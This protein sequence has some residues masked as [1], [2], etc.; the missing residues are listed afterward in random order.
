[1]EGTLS[2]YSILASFFPGNKK[3]Y[4]D[5]IFQEIRSGKN[6]WNENIFNSIH[7]IYQLSSF[8]VSDF[9]FR[10]FQSLEMGSG[11]RKNAFELK[12]GIR[13]SFF[14]SFRCT[15]N[16]T[17]DSFWHD[18]IFLKN[19]I[20]LKWNEFSSRLKKIY[21]WNPNRNPFTQTQS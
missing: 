6:N 5:L 16:V 17:C 3:N 15:S 1:M 11:S 8:F 13:I 20:S 14:F 19:L 9:K 21:L 12:N 4:R 7:L 2:F 10:I 18:M